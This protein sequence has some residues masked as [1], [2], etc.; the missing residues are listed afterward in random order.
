M[1]VK[2]N[3]NVIILAGKDRGKTGKVQR[4]ILKKNRAVVEK[5]NMVKRHQKPNEK[6]RTGG[7][8]EKEAPLHASNLALYCE[9]CGKGVRTHVK[10]V[11]EG[12]DRYASLAEAQASQAESSSHRV[13]KI[14]T[15][16]HCDTSFD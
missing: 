9:K 4:V 15:C 6:N 8:V 7:I 16:V 10:F 3:D 5:L 13:R 11:G 2:K 14:R 12:G 1:H